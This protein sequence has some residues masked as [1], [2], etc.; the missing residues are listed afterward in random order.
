M[1]SFD[2]TRCTCIIVVILTDADVYNVHAH[3]TG[4]Y[5]AVVTVNERNMQLLMYSAVNVVKFCDKTL[6]TGIFRVTE[7][8]Y[9]PCDLHDGNDSLRS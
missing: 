9:I 3:C 5:R 8:Y 6:M 4:H 1:R 7:A 2:N